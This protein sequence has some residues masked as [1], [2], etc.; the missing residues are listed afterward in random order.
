[1]SFLICAEGF[2]KQRF[3]TLLRKAGY[4]CRPFLGGKQFPDRNPQRGLCPLE[5]N[6]AFQGLPMERISLF[7]CLNKS[8]S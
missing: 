4:A 5:E 7:F 8:K 1:M 3:I 2:G 6:C